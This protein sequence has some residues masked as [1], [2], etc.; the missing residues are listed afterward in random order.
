[1]KK[2]CPKMKWGSG[3]CG[4][5]DEQ[6]PTVEGSTG[7]WDNSMNRYSTGGRTMSLIPTRLGCGTL[8]CGLATACG[9]LVLVSAV[10]PAQGQ[11]NPQESTKLVASD[12]AAYANFG[13]AVAVSGESALIGSYKDGGSV[14]SAYVFI[15]ASGTWTQQ[16]KLTASD[17]A[18]SSFFGYS[19]AISGE[20]TVV[21][22]PLDNHDGLYD[23][24][25]AYIFV[26][27][28][29]VWSQQAKLTAFDPVDF[30]R[31]GLSV[32]VFGETVV[33]G[34]YFSQS[35]GPPEAGSAYVYVRTGGVWTHQAKLTASDAAAGDNFGRA[36][37]LSG[38]TAAIGA[39]QDDDNAGSAYVFVRA[40]G[41]WTQQSKLIA[42]DRFAGDRFGGSIAA[43]GET[44]VIG[45][46]SDRNDDGGAGSAYVFVRS[47]DLWTQQAKLTPS[48]VAL[49]GGLF[50]G[51]SVAVSGDVALVGD[52]EDSHPNMIRA[53]AAYLFSRTAGTWTEEVKLTAADGAANDYF[54]FSI[55][56]SGDRALT[57]AISDSH[58][59]GT[60]AGSAYI[61]DLDCDDD[62]VL[63]VNDVCPND[64]NK[65]EPGICGCGVSDVDTDG[66]GTP[67][68]FDAC[69]NN[70]PGLLIDCT[71]RPLRDADNDCLVRTTDFLFIVDELLLVTI[72]PTDCSG[73]PLRDCNGDWLVDG[74]DVTC[75]VDEMLNQ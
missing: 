17:A 65:I 73:Q 70:A 67:D 47:G 24:G 9:L 56:M 60:E 36:V 26:R 1:M 34:Q 63:N 31:F 54:G 30:G 55:A 43:S 42:S 38:E 62:G 35:T 37:A 33:V 29:G 58:A 68:C 72:P 22:A 74:L 66:D 23:P 8:R 64:P 50:F 12:A 13:S 61:I 41:V 51:N 69:P 45:A 6:V 57:G 49:G 59:G 25:S 14:G 5:M 21:G 18:A 19:V 71:G 20:T 16:A 46:S 48:D 28:G 3:S 44:V 53:G 32:A 39:W 15:L 11:C 40:N 10:T 2:I 27:S 75:L 7:E 4:K 52:S